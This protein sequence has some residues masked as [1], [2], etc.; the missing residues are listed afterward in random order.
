MIKELSEGVFFNFGAAFLW[1]KH[2]CFPLDRTF[3]VLA[4]LIEIA[5]ALQ[6]LTSVTCSQ[7]GHHFVFLQD[8]DPKYRAKTTQEWFKKAKIKVLGRPS[9]SPDLN[10]IENMWQKLKIAVHRRSLS[11]V[12]ELK[13][14]CQEE[15][16]KMP[17]F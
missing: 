6:F 14:F 3:S 4:R 1:S 2:I 9:Q 15:W 13:M 7:K 17:Q 16:A 10:P 5:C 12:R 11:N 8:N